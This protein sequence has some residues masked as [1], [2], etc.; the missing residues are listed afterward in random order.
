[1]ATLERGIQ[2][3]SDPHKVYRWDPNA[4]F[5]REQEVF[6]AMQSWSRCSSAEWFCNHGQERD[7]ALHYHSY[8]PEEFSSSSKDLISGQIRICGSCAEKN[9]RL[10]GL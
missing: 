1:M 6:T 10:A 8:Q 5:H 7:K 2:R 4:S 9:F 3:S